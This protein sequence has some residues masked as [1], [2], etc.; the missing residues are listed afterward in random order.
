[1]ATTQRLWLTQ[2]AHDRLREE[3]AEL[4]DQRQGGSAKGTVDDQDFAVDAGRRRG[5]IREIQ[6]LLRNAVVGEAPPDDGV[7][8]PGMVLTVRFDDDETET[9]L[10]GARDG[11]DLD[12][13]SVYSPDSP[14]GAALS[15]AKQGEERTYCVPNGSTVQVTLVRAVPYGRHGAGQP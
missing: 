12:G 2:H 7:A 8:E 6:E 15:G 11:S 1:M 4:L 5:R 13:L 9:F 3:L 14:L 10:L